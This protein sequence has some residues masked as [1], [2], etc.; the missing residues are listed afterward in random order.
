MIDERMGGGGSLGGRS[1]SLARCILRSP[2]RRRTMET[3][4]GVAGQSLSVGVTCAAV[5]TRLALLSGID[6]S[7]RLESCGCGSGGAASQ[8][9]SVKAMEC[10][11]RPEGAPEEA[12]VQ[13]WK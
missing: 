6:I 10:V 13:Y 12:G 5:E 1:E 3:I 9:A 7:P 8:G 11:T 2:I 4:A